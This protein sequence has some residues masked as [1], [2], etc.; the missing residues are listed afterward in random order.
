MSCCAR[1]PALCTQSHI[2]TA[3]K[4]TTSP[5]SQVL[6][7]FSQQP[8]RT[9]RLSTAAARKMAEASLSCAYTELQEGLQKLLALPGPHY[10][11][12]MADPDPATGVSW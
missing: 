5:T 7:L 3:F 9:A 4:R 2:I 1:H 11:L 6:R 10:V 8:H 12:F